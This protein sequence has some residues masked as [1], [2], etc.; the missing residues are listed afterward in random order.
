MSNARSFALIIATA[1]SQGCTLSTEKLDDSELHATIDSK[2]QEQAPLKGSYALFNNP[3]SSTSSRRISDEIIRLID[4]Q[5]S[6]NRDSYLRAGLYSFTDSSIKKALVRAAFRNVI[7]RV[8]LDGCGTPDKGWSTSGGCPN[9]KFIEA[10]YEDS[11]T[12][13]CGL[14]Y[15]L[16]DMGNLNPQER[17]Q[18]REYFLHNQGSH[19]PGKCRSSGTKD[20][21]THP[22]PLSF[23]KR[24]G[25]VRTV[26]AENQ[27]QSCVR[28]SENN[29]RGVQHEKFYMFSNSKLSNG[30]PI[31]DVVLV[32]SANATVAASNNQWNNA[33]VTYGDTKSEWYD[34]WKTHFNLLAD[35]A[36]PGN[37]RGYFQSS[38]TFNSAFFS[39]WNGDDVL[40]NRLKRANGGNDCLVW[41]AHSHIS[42]SRPQVFEELRR[43]QSE[44]CSLRVAL[45]DEGS[46]SASAYDALVSMGA[47]LFRPGH[48]GKTHHHKYILFQGTYDG[49]PDF[50]VWTGSHNLSENSLKNSNDVIVKYGSDAIASGYANNFC[51]MMNNSVLLNLGTWGSSEPAFAA[52]TCLRHGGA[53]LFF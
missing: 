2:H 23:L 32:T 16:N 33:V 53:L 26:G 1:C 21:T 38:D 30:S 11:A 7:V 27:L 25:T 44:G 48:N 3:N 29:P 24:C 35:G 34:P 13:E 45:P 17:T 36:I 4:S 15:Y 5:E 12:H 31:K 43:L 42:Y 49:Q 41:V 8:V 47:L 9:Y 18:V 52:L 51:T 22:A 40:E 14:G 37:Y 20:T 46:V 19:P 6:P 50:R 39:P 10:G 28:S